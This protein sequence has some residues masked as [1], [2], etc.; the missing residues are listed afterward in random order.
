MP[1]QYYREH[2]GDL[3]RRLAEA[4]G[5]AT[6]K[7]LEER[8]GWR[9][10]VV[11]VRHVALYVLVAYLLFRFDEPWIWVPLAALQ[12]VQILGFLILLH[13]QTHG[14]LFARPHPRL[15]RMLGILY[16]LPAA[17]SASQFARWHL[18]HHRE[19]GSAAGDPKRAHLTPKIVARWFKLLYFTPC[20]FAIYTRA[21]AR[22]ARAYSP[23]LRRTIAWER[24]LALAVHGGLA[25]ALSTQGL[26]VVLRVWAAPLFLFFPPAFVI[27]R[28]GQHYDI[29]P[30]RVEAWSTRVDGNPLIRY[31]FLWSNH[32]IEHH[33]FPAVPFYRLPALNRA[34]GPFFAANRIPDRGYLSLLWGWLGENRTPHTR[35]R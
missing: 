23:E 11:A 22:A 17:I 18:D 8:S 13:E 2:S 10:A 4:L 1:E 21:S 12:G 5:P 19:L 26:D 24:L 9:H 16:A 32:H 34:L 30:S 20:L 15:E 35:W 7:S 14:L 28:L 3:D 33:Y 27:N 31:F 6:T 25:W 29:D